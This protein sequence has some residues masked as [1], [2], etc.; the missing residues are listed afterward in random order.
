MDRSSDF[1]KLTLASNKSVLNSIYCSGLA[2]CYNTA[3]LYESCK[4]IEA[5]LLRRSLF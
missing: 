1:L 4:A 2:W 5:E 3:I